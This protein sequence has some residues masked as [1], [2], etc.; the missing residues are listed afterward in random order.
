MIMSRILVSIGPIPARLDSVKYITNRF[1]G[2]LALKTAHNLRAMGHNVVL[3]AWEYLKIKT[4]LPIVRVKDVYDYSRKVLA[5]KADAYILAAAV[6]NLAPLKPFKGKF[7]SHKYSVGDVFPIDFTIAPRV[8]DEIKK[9]HKIATLIGYKLFDGTEKELVQAA[10]KTLFESRANLVFANHPGWAKKRKIVITPDGAS[11]Y[12]DFGG[13]IKLIDKIVRAKFYRTE[14]VAAPKFAPNKEDVFVI[15]NYPKHKGSGMI[16]GAFAIRKAG[17][18]ITTTRGKRAREKATA[19][20]MD[21]DHRK[22]LV[23][24]DKKATL[25]APLLDKL[26]KENPRV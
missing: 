11:F 9:K 15:K 18:F 25:N 21:V 3:V 24:A 1:H 14:I 20:V 13:H 7:P 23:Y 4:R 5:L 17:G 2:G 6:A 8:I 16:F 19:F 22:R 12:V 10:Q 26:F